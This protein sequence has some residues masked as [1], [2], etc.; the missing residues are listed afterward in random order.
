MAGIINTA[1]KPLPSNDELA[2]MNWDKLYQLRT[3]NDGNL[4]AQKIL[5]PY[6]HQAYAREQVAENPLQAPVWALMPIG[7]Q[8]YKA[9]GGG[10]HD[11]MTTPPSMDQAM[12]GI[13]GVGQGMADAVKKILDIKD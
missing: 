9:L 4:E 2:Q 12:A 13:K 11:G 6:E 10:G 3:A 1:A 5:A 8:A 7:Y